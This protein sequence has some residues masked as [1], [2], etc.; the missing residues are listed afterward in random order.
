MLM[1]TWCSACKLQAPTMEYLHDTYSD[2]LV[3]IS[4][5]VDV[6]ETAGMM[7]EYKETN[8]YSHPHGLDCDSN[9]TNYFEVL[10]I[11]TTIIIDSDGYI[12]WKHEAVWAETSIVAILS[13][14]ME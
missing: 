7:A 1:A 6:S 12:R 8:S 11:P 13:K 4:L 5:T 9:I 3:V 10:Y 2:N 14:L